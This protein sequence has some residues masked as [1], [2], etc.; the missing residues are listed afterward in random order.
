MAH[1]T[2]ICFDDTNDN[3]KTIISTLTSSSSWV[4]MHASRSI[5]NINFSKEKPVIT[6]Y[7]LG[8]PVQVI[9]GFFN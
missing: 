6:L 3:K 4:A 9:L 7:N 2:P 5:N 1:L 8:K